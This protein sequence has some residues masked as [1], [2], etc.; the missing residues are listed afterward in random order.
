MQSSNNNAVFC[1]ISVK[2]KRGKVIPSPKFIHA[3]NLLES[4]N[5]IIMYT[6]IVPMSG[7]VMF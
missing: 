5:L 6:L 7:F 1:A 4:N 2:T 3:H